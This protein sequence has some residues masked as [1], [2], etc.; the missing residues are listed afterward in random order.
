M[1]PFLLFLFRLA[2]VIFTGGQKRKHAHA[3]TYAHRNAR[4]HTHTHTHKSITWLGEMQMKQVPMN[5][6]QNCSKMH[7]NQGISSSTPP[8]TPEAPSEDR[9]ARGSA[10]DGEAAE[11]SGSPKQNG[12]ICERRWCFCLTVVGDNV[13]ED[14][15]KAAMRRLPSILDDAMRRLSS[16]HEDAWDVCHPT[17]RMK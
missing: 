16:N 5:Q 4:T 17:T 3:H 7:A 14:G 6:P 2:L 12:N 13:Q 1:Q 10:P 8:P 11:G 9:L 15:H